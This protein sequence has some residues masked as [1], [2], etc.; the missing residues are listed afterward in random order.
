MSYD[1]RAGAGP[2]AWAGWI[3]F[4]AVI[5]VVNGAI[6]IIEGL[7]G[8]FR[9]EAFF[10]PGEVLVLDHATWGWIHL[11]IGIGLVAVGVGL[12]RGARVARALAVVLAMLNLIAHFTSLGAYPWWSIVAI[13]LD[14]LIV[15]ALVVH[16]DELASGT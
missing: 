12:Y 13:A 16:G 11:V 1:D 3:L 15:Y 6:A 7:A 4:A 9:D 5:L 2:T 8:I 10:G 14:V